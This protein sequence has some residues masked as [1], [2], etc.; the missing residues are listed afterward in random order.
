[1]TGSA[2]HPDPEEFDCLRMTNKFFV[3]NTAPNRIYKNINKET[4]QKNI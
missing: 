4:A 1:V 2:G 3:D